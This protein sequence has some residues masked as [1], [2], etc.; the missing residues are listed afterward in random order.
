MKNIRWYNIIKNVKP[1]DR[2]FFN[3]RIYCYLDIWRIYCYI[4]IWHRTFSQNLNITSKVMR[5]FSNII[6]PIYTPVCKAQGRNRAGLPRNN[7]QHA[8]YFWKLFILNAYS[9]V[10]GRWGKNKLLKFQ[11]M[12]LQKLFF[13]Q[14]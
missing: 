1:C 4:D 10:T 5:T 8:T 12:T 7:K 2:N 3:K 6:R 13:N 11:E 9:M 14:L